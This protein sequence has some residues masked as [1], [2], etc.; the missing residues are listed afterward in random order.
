LNPEIPLKI[1]ETK[2]AITNVYQQLTL[3]NLSPGNKYQLL[4]SLITEH[5]SRAEKVIYAH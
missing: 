4:K 3:D 2:R 1:I 5:Q